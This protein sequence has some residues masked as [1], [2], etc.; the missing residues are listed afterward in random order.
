MILFISLYQLGIVLFLKSNSWLLNINGFKLNKEY[1]NINNVDRIAVFLCQ[2][3]ANH[4]INKPTSHVNQ[5]TNI[6]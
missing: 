3:E 5:I 1:I 2:E 4:L 6:R